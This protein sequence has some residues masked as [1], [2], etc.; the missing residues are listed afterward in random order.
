M[1]ALIEVAKIF[2]GGLLGVLSSSAFF[3]WKE[4]KEAKKA[5]EDAYSEALAAAAKNREVTRD[6]ALMLY[7]IIQ[8]ISA[9]PPEQHL[10]EVRKTFQLAAENIAKPNATAA[11]EFYTQLYEHSGEMSLAEAKSWLKQ[12]RHFLSSNELANR[13]MLKKLAFVEVSLAL[14][15]KRE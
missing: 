3:I 11:D 13:S 5:A 2:G 10:I 7:E 15:P 6:G 14:P 12:A 9:M 1:S 8:R 4:R